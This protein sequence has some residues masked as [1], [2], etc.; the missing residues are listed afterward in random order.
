M[1]AFLFTATHL[2]YSYRGRLIAANNSFGLFRC[3]WAVLVD[4]M[5]K[6]GSMAGIERF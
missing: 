3:M 4:F 2:Y 1:D 5:P 6:V